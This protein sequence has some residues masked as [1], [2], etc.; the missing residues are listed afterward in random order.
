MTDCTHFE[1]L[2][3]KVLSG[4][5][6]EAD[7]LR[8]ED[9]VGDCE[10]CHREFENRSALMARIA[11]AKRPDPGEEFWDGFYDRLE[12]RMEDEGVTSPAATA[13]SP[14]RSARASSRDGRSPLTPAGFIDHLRRRLTPVPA[15]SLQLAAVVLLV[16]VGIAIGRQSP[17]ERAAQ[18]APDDRP[19][20][21]HSTDTYD[22]RQA[23]LERQALDTIG[24][25]RTLLLG[26]VNFDPASG[27]T[28]S[29]DIPTRRAVARRL[30]D[31]ASVLK[32]DLAGV[33]RRLLSE[34]ISDLEIILIQI[35]NLE[36][37]ADIPEIEILQNSVDRG[38]IMFKIDIEQMRR[39]S[40]LDGASPD[41]GT[42]PDP[43]V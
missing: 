38:A 42:S 1:T 4:A 8:L 37:S 13:A 28:S 5:A 30:A 32:T 3:T 41:N 31:E 24:R 21:E 33:D 20:S 36:A 26:L 7:R 10:S 43:A 29:L 17:G 15:W 22:I 18:L 25:S 34:L 23:S 14:S 12:T 11:A 16:S 6:D 2:I 19:L 40:G 35:A 39:V 27:N 9:H